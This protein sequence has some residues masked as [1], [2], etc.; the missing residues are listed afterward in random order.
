M[1]ARVPP[2]Y[3]KK[4]ILKTMDEERDHLAQR[5]ISIT[6]G[7]NINS[8]KIDDQKHDNLDIIKTNGFDF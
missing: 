7:F 2:I 1:A 8:F 6:G 3:D 4:W 5:K